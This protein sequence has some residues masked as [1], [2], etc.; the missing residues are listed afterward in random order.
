MKF[1]RNHHSKQAWIIVG[2]LTAIGLV[3]R[4]VYRRYAYRHDIADFGVADNA[5][6]FFSGLVIVLL[7]FTYNNFNPK[8]FLRHALLTFAGLVAYEL[9]QG[10]GVLYYRTFDV[11]DVAATGLGVALG[12]ALGLFLCGKSYVSTTVSRTNQS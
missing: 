3:L 1:I 10:R 2:I 9:V 4:F 8:K 6:N 11:R 5:P 12:Y 7:Y